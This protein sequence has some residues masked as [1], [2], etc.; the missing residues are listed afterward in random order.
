MKLENTSE[1]QECLQEESF[2]WNNEYKGKFEYIEN[3]EW[4]DEGKYSTRH[5]IIK[6]LEHNKFYITEEAITG[7]YYTEYVN[8]WEYTKQLEFKEVEC[9]EVVKTEWIAVKEDK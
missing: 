1:L 8:D 5:H 3:S 9:V 7:S 2:D 6:D 4:I